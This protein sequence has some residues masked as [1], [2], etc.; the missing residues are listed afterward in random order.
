MKKISLNALRESKLLRY[1]IFAAVAVI[2]VLLTILVTRKKPVAEKPDTVPAVVIQKPENGTLLESVTI[3]GY[4]EA[5][6][7]IPVVPFVSGTIKE[8]PVRAGDFVEKD[9]LLAKIDDAPFRQQMLQAQAAYFAAQST[10]DRINNLYKSGATTQQNYDSAKAQADASKAQYDL[11]KLQVDYTEVRAPVDGTILI[12]DQAVGGIGNQ[13]Q[14]VAVLADLTNQVVRLKVPE[15]YFDLFT[16][17]R[18]NLKV[19]VTRPAEKNMYEDAV[20][21]A[22]I[23]NIAPYVS[24]QSKNFIVVCHLDEPGDR[25]RPGMFVKVQVAYKTYE[26]VPLISLKARKM[27]GSFYIFDENTSTVK[28]VEGQDFP[29]DE[30]NFIVPEEYRNSYIVMDGQNFVFDGQKVRVFEEA[31][32][33][34]KSTD[35]TGE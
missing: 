9:T 26:N 20:T 14:P 16:L 6:A 7:M 12:A 8:Y 30:N 5:N 29:V 1:A 15:K 17:E 34:A 4:V 10:F 19:I 13:T 24:P 35:R 3:S 25:F 2:F 22:T 27:D 28:Y 18:D 32:N 33:E 21:T 23:E 31:L 11:A